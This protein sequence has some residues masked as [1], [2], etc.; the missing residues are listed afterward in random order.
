MFDIGWVEMMIVVVVMVVVIGPK[1]LPVVLHTMGKWIARVRAM[2]RSFQDSIEEMAGEAGLDQMRDEV[3]SIR[4]YSLEDEIEKAID[5]EDE[6][7]EGIYGDPAK[8]LES[9]K[10]SAGDGDSVEHGDA[11]DST[12]APE[13]KP[14]PNAPA[15]GEKT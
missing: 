10:D 9:A 8:A 11:D 15:P 1:D 13:P 3:Q 14:E 5:S 7:S 6:P 4:D 2:A 12:P